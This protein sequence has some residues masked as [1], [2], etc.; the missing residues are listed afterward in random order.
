[1]ILYFE[2]IPKTQ[3]N[4]NS[5]AS[6]VSLVNDQTK[7]RWGFTCVPSNAQCSTSCTLIN[8][9][10]VLYGLQRNLSLKKSDI[11]NSSHCQVMKCNSWPYSKHGR[12]TGM[13]YE[14]TAF[15]PVL[16]K[17]SRYSSTSSIERHCKL[18]VHRVHYAMHGNRQHAQT[19]IST[20]YP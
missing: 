7:Q 8:C 10:L 13:F 5:Q 11:S 2:K 20:F 4:Q 12:N 19:P 16:C 14:P 15:V 6:R 17:Q 1:M 18:V 9:C 3:V